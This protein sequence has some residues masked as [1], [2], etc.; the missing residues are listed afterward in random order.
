YQFFNSNSSS[1]TPTKDELAYNDFY[2]QISAGNIKSATIIGSTDITGTFCTPV[3][4]SAGTFTQYHVVQLPNGD[5]NL[6]PTLIKQ[7]PNMTC[8]KSSSFLRHPTNSRD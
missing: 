6:T 7:K 8:R 5:P 4:T 2:T 1:N 3:T